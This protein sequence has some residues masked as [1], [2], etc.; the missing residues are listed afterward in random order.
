[1]GNSKFSVSEL[2]AMV[3]TIAKRYLPEQ[4]RS[5]GVRQFANLLAR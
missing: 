2:S 1:M 4:K 3:P 5:C